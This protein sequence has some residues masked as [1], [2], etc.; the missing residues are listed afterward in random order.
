MA[1]ILELSRFME[2]WW[3]PG[4]VIAAAVLLVILF[5]VAVLLG[6]LLNVAVKHDSRDVTRAGEP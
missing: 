2:T 1:A 4:A 3:A 5:E 6:V